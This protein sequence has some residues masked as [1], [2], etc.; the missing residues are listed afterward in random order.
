MPG[1]GRGTGIIPKHDEREIEH[2]EIEGEE[3]EDEESYLLPSARRVTVL[4]VG[5]GL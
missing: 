5:G 1:T 2:S 3:E 4:G